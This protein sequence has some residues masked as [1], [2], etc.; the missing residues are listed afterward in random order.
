MKNGVCPKCN[1]RH[2]VPGL[3]VHPDST[4]TAYCRITAPADKAKLLQRVGSVKSELYA[5]I[6]GACGY[7]ELYATQ[8][9]ELAAGY[10]Q[11][12]RDGTA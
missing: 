11:G 2:V 12:W 5:W 8:H 6:C 9:A 1:S 10:Q 7:T 4:H 3:P